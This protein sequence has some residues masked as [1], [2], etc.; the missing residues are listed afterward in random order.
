MI[1][2]KHCN[3]QIKFNKPDGFNAVLSG[4]CYKNKKTK[5]VYVVCWNCLKA[6]K[7]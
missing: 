7:L 3:K 5:E 6:I 1:I 2:C 4:K